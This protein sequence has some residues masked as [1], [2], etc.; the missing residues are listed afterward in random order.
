VR[1]EQVYSETEPDRN[2]N[3]FVFLEDRLAIGTHTQQSLNR[4]NLLLGPTLSEGHSHGLRYVKFREHV[5]WRFTKSYASFWRHQFVV[6]LDDHLPGSSQSVFVGLVVVV[7]SECRDGS[8]LAQLDRDLVVFTLVERHQPH[9]PVVDSVVSAIEELLEST[10]VR[11]VTR[12]GVHVSWLGINSC[13]T[14]QY[15]FITSDLTQSTLYNVLKIVCLHVK[16]QQVISL[17]GD[18]ADRSVLGL[19][20]TFHLSDV[21]LARGDRRESGSC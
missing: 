5:A 9:V 1:R 10:M 3:G 20:K 2:L 13:L 18:E 19:S 4:H 21:V 8:L 6:D 11:S 15:I 12:D 16:H 14:S 7:E 17:V